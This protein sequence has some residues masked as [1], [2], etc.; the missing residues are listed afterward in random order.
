[1]GPSVTELFQQT[2]DHDAVPLVDVSNDMKATVTK[3]FWEAFFTHQA[4]SRSLRLYFV[5]QEKACWFYEQLVPVHLQQ[6][7]QDWGKAQVNL[8]NELINKRNAQSFGGQPG[9]T[10]PAQV[11]L[12]PRATKGRAGQVRIL[13]GT[14]GPCLPVQEAQQPPWLIL[15]KLLNKADLRMSTRE[16]DK[17]WAGQQDGWVKQLAKKRKRGGEG[18]KILLNIMILPIEKKIR[19]CFLIPGVEEA[20]FQCDVAKRTWEITATRPA[21]DSEYLLQEFPPGETLTRS[22][23]LHA[24]IDV[25]RRDAIK[26]SIKDGVV[27]VTFPIYIIYSRMLIQLVLP[28]FVLFE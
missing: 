10:E 9:Q 21:D 13:Y 24:E 14:K 2:A 28:R 16:L 18:S 12:A 3:A 25:S 7:R 27:T 17:L 15:Q 20:A 1:V 5:E 26:K 6:R 23:E 19:Y 22:G 4:S 11:A 8:L